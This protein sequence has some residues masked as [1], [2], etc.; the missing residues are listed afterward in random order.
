MEVEFLNVKSKTSNSR[1]G[2]RLS[3]PSKHESF[4]NFNRWSSEALLENT[5]KNF[6]IFQQ[7][8]DIE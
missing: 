2:C 3:N 1:T 6:E 8:F 5:P 4:S 7:H